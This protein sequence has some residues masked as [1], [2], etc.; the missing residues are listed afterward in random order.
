MDGDRDL[1]FDILFTR[2][3]IWYCYEEFTSTVLI[4]VDFKAMFHQ[5][6][7]LILIIFVCIRNRNSKA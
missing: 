7:F 2:L 3:L 6:I 1:L 5:K 4:N